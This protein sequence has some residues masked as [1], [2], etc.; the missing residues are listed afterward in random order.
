MKKLVGYGFS[1]PSKPSFL[2]I[3]NLLLQQ[4]L[5][6]GRL[7]PYPTEYGD[8]NYWRQGLCP[9]G[10]DCYH[11]NIWH[12]KEP[13]FYFEYIIYNG[14]MAIAPYRYLFYANFIKW[15]VGKRTLRVCK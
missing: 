13:K 14:A 3:K 9:V 10:G 15:C 5:L 12:K 4:F 7:K 2:N 1:L 8:V 11:T 6:D